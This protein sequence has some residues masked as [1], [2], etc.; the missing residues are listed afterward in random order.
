MIS[1]V[2]VFT[3][4]YGHDTCLSVC[5]RK[6]FL[7]SKDKNKILN[8][9]SSARARARVCVC[10]CVCVCECAFA[11]ILCVCVCVCVCAWVYLGV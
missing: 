11:S 4:V 7:D 2:Y 1:C 6:I 8:N 10:V 9:E 3:T 5:D